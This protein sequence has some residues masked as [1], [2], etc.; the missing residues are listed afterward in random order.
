M[1]VSPNGRMALFCETQGIYIQNE[2]I[3]NGTS[4]CL[5]LIMISIEADIMRETGQLRF[6]QK[7]MKNKKAM[8]C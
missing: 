1:K 8:I 2:I 7:A 4:T 6:E 5:V 3:L